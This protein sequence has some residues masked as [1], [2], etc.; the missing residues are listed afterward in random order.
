M[1]SRA[2]KI[3]A[4]ACQW[5]EQ[6]LSNRGFMGLRAI[7]GLL[8]LTT[9]HSSDEIDK[10]CRIALSHDAFRVKT[11]RALL[12]R[13]EGEQFH[14]MEDHP[15]IREMKEYGELVSFTPWSHEGKEKLR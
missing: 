4:H 15:V 2:G 7:Q 1:L 10:A 5:A 14:F 13:S 8:S 12:K 3:G 11:L 9:K 6:L